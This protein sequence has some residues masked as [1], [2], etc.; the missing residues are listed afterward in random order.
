L[1]ELAARSGATAA[2]RAGLYAEAVQ[3]WMLAGDAARAYAAATLG[4]SLMPEDA[5]LLLDRAL[6]AGNLGRYAEALSDLDRVLAADPR[7]AEAWAF[8]AAALRRMERPAEALVAAE[9]ALALDPDHPE[10]LLERGILRQAAGDSEGARAD[11]Q[12]LLAVAPDSAAADLAQQNLELL[13]AGPA[14]R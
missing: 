3:G 14:G 1:E 11:W 2:E 10:A 6:A 12:R 13:E 9:R 7:R 4:L 8:R 5:G